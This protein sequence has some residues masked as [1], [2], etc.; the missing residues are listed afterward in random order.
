[1]VS[2][3]DSDMSNLAIFHQFITELARSKR[4]LLVGNDFELLQQLAM[5]EL[6]ELI[7]CDSSAD[8]NAPDG[9]TPLGSLLRFRADTKRSVLARKTSSLIYQVCSIKPRWSGY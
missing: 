3:R 8:P 5:T 6:S 7:V 2:V 9:L 4:V 1:M